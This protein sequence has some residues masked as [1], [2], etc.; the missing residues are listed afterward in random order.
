MSQPSRPAGIRA[1]LLDLDDT[2]LINKM[3]DF[4]PA[5]LRLISGY[6]AERYEPEFFV[7]R[8]MAATQVM[9]SNTDPTV[10]N[11]QAFWDEFS[12]LTGADPAGLIPFFARFY[13]TIFDKLEAKTA[14][15]PQARSLVQWALHQGY[16]VVIATNPM[17]PRIAVDRRLA[18]AGIDDLDYHLVTSYENMHFVKPHPEYY[19]EIL[20][21]LGCAPVQALMVGDD[22]ERDIRPASQV[23]LHTF[24]VSLPDADLPENGIAISGRGTLADFWN[25]CQDG[26]LDNN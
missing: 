20:L 13:E 23:G 19:Q 14:R 5:Y 25:L 18:W 4:L 2:L 22:W 26:W 3:D 1:L 7:S 6:A 10:T 9:A 11:E 24:W 8:M 15:Q 17:F 21:R 16:R 12:R